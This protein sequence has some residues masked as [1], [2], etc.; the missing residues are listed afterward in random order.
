MW[1]KPDMHDKALRYEAHDRQEK[2]QILL[3]LL[4]ALLITACLLL[5]TYT[6]FDGWRE[7]LVERGRQAGRTELLGIRKNLFLLMGNQEMF[8]ALF[9]QRLEESLAAGLDVNLSELA[10]YLTYLEHTHPSFA[11]ATITR[12]SVLTDS[13]FR[14][15]LH[16]F[17]FDVETLVHYEEHIGYTLQMQ[18][19]TLDGPLQGENGTSYLVSRYALHDPD[20]LW[21][22]LTLHFD[23]KQVLNEAG[24]EEVG[25]DYRVFFTFVHGSDKES[26]D[27]GDATTS[28]EEAVV[29]DLSYSLLK[30]RMQIVPTDS[31]IEFSLPLFLYGIVSTLV[32]IAIG[33]FI[34]LY[35][36]K[37]QI[38][39]T[40]SRTDSMT[41]LLNRREFEMLLHQ[42]CISGEPF[43]VALIDIDNF[44]EINDV[45]GHLNGDKA[46]LSLVGNL[47]QHIRMSDA[48]ARFGGDEF[49]LLFHGCT[50]V[51]FCKRLFQD[52]A[53]TRVD[54][55]G[56]QVEVV[57]SMGVVLSDEHS[58]AQ[59]LVKIA[60]RR[61]YQAKQDG[62][63]R[64]CTSG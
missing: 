64:I 55:D 44:K 18:D 2:S 40:R 33:V 1:Q 12:E 5:I 63:G 21:G 10:S 19:V 37:F 38:F 36:I 13:Y 27:W 49:I 56:E 46:L 28:N 35:Q 32:C 57:I 39:K 23:F 30:W 4:Q 34:Y 15:G 26:F 14:Q 62:K 58:Q 53:H 42:T 48:L 31:W 16:A 60:D 7:R 59:A 52:I 22:L 17:D 3:A 50:R 9:G 20:G 47:K 43:A 54:L 8:T 41:G 25:E 24:V 61:L 11:F 29:M 51:D 6:L 45:H